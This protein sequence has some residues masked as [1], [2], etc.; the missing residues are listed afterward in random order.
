MDFSSFYKSKKQKR[1]KILV[2]SFTNYFTINFFQDKNVDI[3]RFDI[4]EFATL[5]GYKNSDVILE[6]EILPILKNLNNRQNQLKIAIDLP[7]SSIFRGNSYDLNKIISFVKET[8][9]DL[10]VINYKFVDLIKELNFLRELAHPIG[11]SFGSE[12]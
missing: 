6:R 12:E 4:D 2:F 7:I 5:N 11:E 10:L 3:L 9:A 1:E 8:N